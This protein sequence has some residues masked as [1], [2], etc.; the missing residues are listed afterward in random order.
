MFLDIGADEARDT[1]DLMFSSYL[2][3][4]RA[5]GWSGASEDVRLGFCATTA[6]MFALGAL[7][8]WLP[9]L[10]DPQFTPV[11]KGTTGT[12]P[13]KFIDNL[14]KIQGFFLNLGEEAVELARR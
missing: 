9:L 14:S 7:G 6:M 5:K 2:D 12:D 4:L 1:S 13:D 8:P 10:R 11:V 3:G